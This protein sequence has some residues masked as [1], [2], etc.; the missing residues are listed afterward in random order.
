MAVMSGELD[1]MFETWA[2]LPQ[3]QAASSRPWR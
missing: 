1:T 2:A 3:I